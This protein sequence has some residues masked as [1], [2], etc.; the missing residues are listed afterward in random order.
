MTD[1]SEHVLPFGLLPDSAEV[2][3][4]GQLLIGGC[5]LADLAEQYGTPLF[6]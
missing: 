3:P 6:V 5:D 2:G 4:D 1:R